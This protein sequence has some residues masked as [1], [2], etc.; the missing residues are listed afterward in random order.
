MNMISPPI[1]FFPHDMIRNLCQSCLYIN[2]LNYQ[3]VAVKVGHV[4][5]LCLT[6]IA[7]VVKIIRE[8]VKYFKLNDNFSISKCVGCS[9]TVLWRKFVTLNSYITKELSKNNF[10]FHYPKCFLNRTK[11]TNI[12]NNKVNNKYKSRNQ[13]NRKETNKIRECE[14]S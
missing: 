6:L 13:W 12:S 10:L 5:Y 3:K 7:T 14:Q 1:S 9:E 8:I 11:Q 4:V 2:K